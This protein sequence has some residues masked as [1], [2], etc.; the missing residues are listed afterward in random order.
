MTV[1]E[2]LSVECRVTL[3]RKGGL[4]GSCEILRQIFLTKVVIPQYTEK[5]R[6]IYFY[7]TPI[8]SY[9]DGL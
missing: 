2:R 6:V 3:S 9:I 7:D 4:T 8:N 5:K 1:A